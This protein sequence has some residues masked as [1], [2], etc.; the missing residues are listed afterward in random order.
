M[1]RST[2]APHG[3][4]NTGGLSLRVF[5][6]GMRLLWIA[7]AIIIVVVELMPIPL[8]PPKPFYVYCAMKALLF[9]LL[10]FI[11]PLAFWRFNA[12]NR[13]IF[14]ASVSAVC[15]ETLQGLLRN[16]H[17]FHWYELVLKLILIFAGFAFA[18][19]AVFDQK[20]SL[21]PIRASDRNSSG[22]PIVRHA[23]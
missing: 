16:G 13:G 23:Q 4:L 9:V 5:T 19:N 7:I 22:S 1:V 10:G 14:L 6:R 18:L 8:M 20:I 2:T 3:D 11:A 12:L 17:S 21:G 15:V